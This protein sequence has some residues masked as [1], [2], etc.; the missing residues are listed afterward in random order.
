MRRPD[1]I[2]EHLASPEIIPV[3][4]DIKKTLDIPYVPV[5]FQYLA[6]YPRLFAHVWP[7]LKDNLLDPSF[8]SLINHITSDCIHVSQHLTEHFP[9][10]S[11]NVNQLIQSQ[12]MRNRIHEEIRKYF[13]L[14]CVLAFL[15]VAMRESTKGW[16]IGAKYLHSEQ[17]FHVMNDREPHGVTEDIRAMIVAETTSA[18]NVSPDLQKP[19]VSFIIMLHEE[20]A[21]LIKKEEY[22]YARVQVEQS[23]IQYIS[24]MPHTIQTSYNAVT[25]LVED[26]RELPYLFYLLSDKF[27]VVH[28]VATLMWGIGLSVSHEPAGD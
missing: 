21:D 9:N 11:Q 14:Q 10:I 7:S 12:D 26:P 24:N 18:L 5:L 20:F 8:E 19:L 6:N 3:Y 25:N 13:T 23:L 1:P 27:P 15:C 17:A 4:A 28:A 22:L 2:P 16:A